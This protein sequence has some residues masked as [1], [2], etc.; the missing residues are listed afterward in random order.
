MSLKVVFMGTPDFSVPV[1][2]QIIKQGH[3]VVA[4]YT[5]APALSGR[6][7]TIRPSP[8]HKKADEYG[9]T[10]RTPKTLKNPEIIEEFRKL[11]S[12]VAVVAAY[13]L[14]LP[15][16]ILEA[17]YLG[18]L[19]VHASLL[20]RWRGAAPIQ[21]AIMAGD[22]V[23]GVSIMRMAE[24]LDTGPVAMMEKIIICENMT[25]GEL[26]DKMSE[27]G[28]RLMVCVL[29]GLE[30]GNVTFSP[31]DDVNAVYASKITNDDSRIDWLQ[32]AATVHNQVRGLSPFPGAFFEADLGKGL[33]RVRVLK[34][35]VLLDKV[36]QPAGTYFAEG[37]I[38]CKTGAV[39]LLRVQRA[40]KAPMD[41]DAFLR[42]VRL[43]F[44]THFV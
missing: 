40:G 24:G 30:S 19:N 15:K 6:G 5:R 21:R 38:A 29:D 36:D 42:G 9:L 16:Q 31:Q 41:A 26:H 2:S 20:P 35:M 39:R 3:D 13:G 28:A 1:L 23:S 37:C 34:T 43:P 25:A 17:P 22:E 12:D 7:M 27:L 33:E 11:E 18:C 14:L 32:D 4:V 44:G 8:V 10:V